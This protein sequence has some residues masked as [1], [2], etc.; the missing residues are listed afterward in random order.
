MESTGIEAASGY[1]YEDTGS[2]DVL[3]VKVESDR[4]VPMKTPISDKWECFNYITYDPIAGD[5]V[6]DDGG[7][8]LHSII[9]RRRQARVLVLAR[10]RMVASSL[11]RELLGKAFNYR[12]QRVQIDV[13]CLVSNLLNPN[14]ESEYTLTQS[15]AKAIEYE[16]AL[17]TASFYGENLALSNIFN[18][19]AKRTN[20][21]F[22]ACGLK[23]GANGA[24]ALK[25]SSN[26]GVTF[27]RSDEI[28]LR[29]GLAALS[30]LQK[31]GY[32]RSRDLSF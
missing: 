16:G 5:E 15:H 7:P 19:V 6:R 31:G 4:L 2:G 28:G 3:S 18:E 9:I 12:L 24:D 17:E 23:N 10:S 25:V 27:P 8:Y 22:Y 26:G 21:T 14:D 32:T 13:N 30:F 11:V 29:E 1:L 20:V